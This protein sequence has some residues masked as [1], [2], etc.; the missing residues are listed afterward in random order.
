MN[1]RDRAAVLV[2]M[3][4]PPANSPPEDGIYVPLEVILDRMRD[5][6]PLRW[7][8]Y[9]TLGRVGNAPKELALML[10]G[11]ELSVDS[12]CEIDGCC[13]LVGQ[14]EDADEIIKYELRE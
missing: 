11:D 13:Q 5:G 2:D 6:E 4:T 3:E 9:A 14:P 7:V 1:R 8:P 12:F 10:G